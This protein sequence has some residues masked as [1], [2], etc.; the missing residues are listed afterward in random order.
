MESVIKTIPFHLQAYQILRESILS[1]KLQPGERLRELKLSQ[2]L[3]VSRSPV[4]EAMRMLEQD[5]L[6]VNLDSGTVVNP[7][8]ID[9][10][11]EVYQCRIA[12]EAYAGFLA[13]QKIN[14]DEIAELIHLVNEAE[15]AYGKDDPERVV[16]LNTAFHDKIVS[17]SGNSR[18]IEI[19][20]KIRSLSI[21]SRNRE[22]KLYSRSREYLDEHKEII[23]AL[24]DKDPYKVE[25]VI[26]KHIEKDWEYYSLQYEAKH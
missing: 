6:V 13:V 26:R 15:I 16:A 1:G 17:I 7:M 10:I 11:K 8:D 3:G 20:E 2:Q 25:K 22:V 5:G 24:K 18:L 23:D 12:S 4:R 9:D 21:L 14:D 19:V